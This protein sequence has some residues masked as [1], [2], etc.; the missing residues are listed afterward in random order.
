M[1]YEKVTILGA[2]SFG[3]AIAVLFARNGIPTYVLDRSQARC[4]HINAHHRNPDY[5]TTSEL[6]PNIVA[7]TDSAEAFKDTQLVFH[8]V[9]VQHSRAYLQDHKSFIGSTPI[10]SM[11]KGIHSETLELMCDIIADVFGPSHDAA[12]MSGPSFAKEIVDGMPT[13]FCIASKSA[14]LAR[15]VADVISRDKRVRC[16]ITD[17]VI[18]V[19][20]GG[21]M[22]N[23]Y[24]IACGVLEAKGYKHN[25]T[26]LLIVRGLNEIIALAI[27]AGARPLTFLGLSGVGDLVLTTMGGQSRNRTF[28]YKLG[29]G[30]K[31]VAEILEEMETVEGA[32]TLKSARQLAERHGILADLPILANTYAVVYEGASI[33]QC[34]SRMMTGKRIRE[35][36]Q[37]DDEAHRAALGGT[38]QP[39]EAAAKPSQ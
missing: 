35:E 11:S 37:F 17:D 25:T 39:E 24:A 14:A 32:Y 27:K 28:G 13:G 10:V 3:T 9:P 26:A 29:L 30:D 38:P 19:E 1:V 5:L 7:T 20:Y 22:K 12:F 23:I 15:R 16:Y 21:A 4:D 18:G 33:E 34:I 8:A 2:G 36:F 6:P 31:T